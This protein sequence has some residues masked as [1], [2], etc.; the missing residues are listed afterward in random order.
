M[1]SPTN[2]TIHRRYRGCRLGSLIR[3]I[4]TRS[5]A[6][7]GAVMLGLVGAEQVRSG[8][9]SCSVR[10]R[11]EEGR[12]G[13]VR[14]TLSRLSMPQSPQPTGPIIERRRG[15]GVGGGREPEAR[16]KPL[17]VMHDLDFAQL[18]AVTDHALGQG[19]AAGEI[20]QIGWAGHHH[21]QR[22]RV[23]D[24]RHRHLA[25][26]GIERCVGEVG[27]LQGHATTSTGVPLKAGVW[28]FFS[29]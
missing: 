28:E 1:P 23:A 19:K 15:A 10:R 12:A 14:S 7:V 5:V 17:G 4:E 2:L 6:T 26:Q 22:H 16:L 27:G 9:G 13:S 24:E 29:W 3:H 18:G 20:L 21:A 8:A 11:V 25:Y